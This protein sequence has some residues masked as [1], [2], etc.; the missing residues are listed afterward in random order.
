MAPNP[1]TNP[2]TNPTP[3]LLPTLIKVRVEAGGRGSGHEKPLV[4]P[5]E[6]T[7]SWDQGD[8]DARDHD[9]DMHATEIIELFWNDAT[10]LVEEW[11]SKGAKDDSGV[12]DNDNDDGDG[13][14]RGSR[15][16]RGC[17]H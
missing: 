13:V 9:G 1:T 3:N 6:F 14:K 10:H 12:A 4:R 2:T 7:G 11:I 17:N 16:G 5:V 15:G 8:E